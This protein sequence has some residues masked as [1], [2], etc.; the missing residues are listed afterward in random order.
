MYLHVTDEMRIRECP[1][2]RK[3]FC[4]DGAS[5]LALAAAPLT[6]DLT[7]SSRRPRLQ[8]QARAESNVPGLPRRI[9]RKGQGLPVRT[10]G[11]SS[12][13]LHPPDVS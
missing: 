4:P 9:L 13:S 10:V 1:R 12:L 2:Y 3:G 6:A 5:L 7:R 11:F 8:A